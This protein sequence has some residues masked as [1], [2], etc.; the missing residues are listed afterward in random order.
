MAGEKRTTYT[1]RFED[2][3][4]WIRGYRSRKV[5]NAEAEARHYAAIT[6]RTVE[7]YGGEGPYRTVYSIV[8]AEGR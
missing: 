2:T 7:I 8:K 3:K 5:K 4:E 6:G 1:L